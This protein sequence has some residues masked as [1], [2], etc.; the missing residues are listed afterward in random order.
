M[1]DKMIRLSS[2][3]PKAFLMGIVE[4][5]DMVGPEE[6]DKWMMSIGKKLGE[7]EGPGVEGAREDGINFMPIC[8]FANEVVE[9]VDME[10]GRPSQFMDIIKH[11]NKARDESDR[12]WEFPAISNIFCILHHSYRK[13]R[14]EMAGDKMLHLGCKSPLSA[15]VAYN[16][17]AIEKAGMSRDDVDK[18]LEKSVCVFKIENP[19]E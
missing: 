2:M 10:G 19:M 13:H 16:D 14:A 17:K 12:G 15:A 1:G 7:K 5:V 8:P 9:F 3:M 6:A 4:L 11:T 18:V